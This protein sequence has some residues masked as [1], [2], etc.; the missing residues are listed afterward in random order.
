[1]SYQTVIVFNITSRSNTKYGETIS[2]EWNEYTPPPHTHTHT[3][4]RTVNVKFFQLLC[5]AVPHSSCYTLLFESSLNFVLQ[6]VFFLR[7]FLS[8][9]SLHSF[10]SEQ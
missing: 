2:T 6:Q 3:H 5:H 1:M 8:Y 9:F 4:A 10:M 7:S